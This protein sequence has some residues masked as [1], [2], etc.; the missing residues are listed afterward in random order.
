MAEPTIPPCEYIFAKVYTSVLE[1]ELGNGSGT[2]YAKNSALEAALE[3]VKKFK[4]L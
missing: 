1:G 3:A 4:A 2:T